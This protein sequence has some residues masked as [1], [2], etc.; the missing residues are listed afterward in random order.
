[1]LDAIA[2]QMPADGILYLGGAETVLGIHKWTLGRLYTM[3]ALPP[4]AD[5]RQ[6]NCHLRFVPKAD[7]RYKIFQ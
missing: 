5:I 7:I 1:V 6:R 2:Q 4:K 3:S